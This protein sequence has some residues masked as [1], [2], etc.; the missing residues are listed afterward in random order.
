MAAVC[1]CVIVAVVFVDVDDNDVV[2]VVVDTTRHTTA[3]YSFL[4]ILS[5]SRLLSAAVAAVVS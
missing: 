4:A 3:L 1:G 2:V 5:I